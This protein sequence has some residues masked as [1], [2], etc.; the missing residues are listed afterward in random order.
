MLEKALSML[1]KKTKGG[2]LL[3][4]KEKPNQSDSK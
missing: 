3:K 2:K 1:D 4:R